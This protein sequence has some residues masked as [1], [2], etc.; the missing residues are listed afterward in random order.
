MA[1]APKILYKKNSQVYQIVGLKDNSVSPAVYLNTATVTAT[2]KDST[3]A[4]VAGF[5]N[6]SGAY[7]SASNGVYN[8]SVDPTLFD[9]P[10]GGGYILAVTA[11]Q[12][13]K[14]W[15]VETP[16][17]VAVRQVGTEV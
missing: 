12:N 17:K 16:F 3:G 15:Y 5:T 14:Q 2:L 9:P 13:S 6:V 8:F 1:V 7:V 4:S 10:A 11:T